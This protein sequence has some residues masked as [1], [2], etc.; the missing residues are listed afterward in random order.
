MAIRARV[1]PASLRLGLLSELNAFD[2]AASYAPTVLR[3]LR[4]VSIIDNPI[5]VYLTC[6]TPT[7]FS[8]LTDPT[9]NPAQSSGAGGKDAGGVGGMLAG[10]G[11]LIR[12][13][14][15]AMAGVEKLAG[16]R[17]TGVTSAGKQ[18]AGGRAVLLVH[19]A[20]PKRVA[21]ARFLSHWRANF[22]RG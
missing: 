18:G 14:I 3:H 20:S 16:S 8:T 10:S 7:L 9:F 2:G 4:E 15:E 11:W 22:A 13:A 17:G 12:N 19:G 21:R 6:H 5:G 1:S